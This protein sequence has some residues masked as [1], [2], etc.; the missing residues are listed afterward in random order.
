MAILGAITALMGVG[1]SIYLQ[2]QPAMNLSSRIAFENLLLWVWPT[3]IMMMPSATASTS[4][5]IMI[6]L[7]AVAANIGLYA[8]AGFAIGSLREKYLT[9]KG[10]APSPA[11]EGSALREAQRAILL[12]AVVSLVFNAVN[13]GGSFLHALASGDVVW[14]FVLLVP[15]TL[16]TVLFAAPVFLILRRWAALQRWRRKKK[17]LSTENGK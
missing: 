6:L 14:C 5:A 16:D 9:A 17:G 15:F 11:T 13:L 2:A 1:L 3:S 10:R 7:M 4:V 8:L 12:G